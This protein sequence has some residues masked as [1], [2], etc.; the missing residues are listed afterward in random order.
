MQTLDTCTHS[1]RLH[2]RPS[3]IVKS[4]FSVIRYKGGGI[5]KCGWLTHTWRKMIRAGVRCSAKGAADLLGGWR[6]RWGRWSGGEEGECCW[7]DCRTHFNAQALT[8]CSGPT[9]R[10][11]QPTHTLRFLFFLSQSPST[12][13]RVSVSHLP[14][15]FWGSLWRQGTA[16]VEGNQG[17]WLT[18]FL[19]TFFPARF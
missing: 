8:Y 5:I 16:C 4:L 11:P 18:N 9:T 19:R 2:T 13:A 6:G 1:P 7:D 12:P 10:F 14:P 3:H 15:H 17:L